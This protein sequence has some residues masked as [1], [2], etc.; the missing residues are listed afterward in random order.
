MREH[1][2]KHQ[3]IDQLYRPNAVCD[4]LSPSGWTNRETLEATTRSREIHHLRASADR[5]TQTDSV[6]KYLGDGFHINW[7]PN[8][9]VHLAE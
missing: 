8:V 7:L 3:P 4:L 6:V 1:S 2:N 9:N 5:L